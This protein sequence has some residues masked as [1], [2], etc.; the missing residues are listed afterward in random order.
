M[1][2]HLKGNLNGAV[3]L[4]LR[5]VTILLKFIL[6]IILIRSL[7]VDQYGVFGLF[8]SN[9]IIL[10]FVIGFDFY[11]FS[12]REILNGDPVNHNS[13]LK[14][15][16]IF[17]TIGYLLI[18]PITFG[19][20]KLEIV[21]SKF[22][23]YF[24][25]ILIFEHISQ[26]LYRLLILFGKT[27]ISTVILFFRSG[28][29]VALLL[30]LTEYSDFQI[31]IELVLI[32]WAIG[33]LISVLIG[34]KYLDFKWVKGIDFHWIRNG[35][36]ISIPFLIGTIFYKLV[37][38]SGRYFLKFYFSDEAV[39]VFTFFSS[40]ANI[41]FVFVQTLVIIELYPALIESRKSGPEN[42]TVIF[43]KFKKKIYSVTFLGL[44][45][46]IVGIYPLLLFL[47]K[48]ELFENILSYLVLIIST[49]FFCL[50][51]IYHYALYAFNRDLDLLKA[52]GII[53][54]CNLF[55]SFS[56]VPLYG[57]LGA[58]IAQ[59]GS[60][61]CIYFSKMYYWNKNSKRR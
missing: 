54:L 27:I 61:V 22:L 2:L 19:L 57:I 14:N 10:T 31:T 24:I 55:L 41:L 49:F 11:T 23:K 47:D 30:V 18:I 59:L 52:A 34:I 15:Q 36:S 25:L 60:F 16:F 5:A 9:V 20:S 21:P 48:L 56:L 4:T 6:S 37:E 35:I 51:F 8:Q 26:E 50:S 45:L 3:N 43:K 32:L 28:I 42:F 46:S 53:L 7:G 58:S 33:A 1:K 39:G 38:F 40:I 17:H 29:W 13:Y 44:L 12:A